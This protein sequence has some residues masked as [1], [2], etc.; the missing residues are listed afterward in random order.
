MHRVFLAP[1][2][3]PLTGCYPTAILRFYTSIERRDGVESDCASFNFCSCAEAEG[4][5]QVASKGVTLVS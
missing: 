5:P 1:R 4:L 3:A 2:H